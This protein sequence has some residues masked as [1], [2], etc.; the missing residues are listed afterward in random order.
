M[1]MHGTWYKGPQLAHHPHSNPHNSSLGH[2]DY[3]QFRSYP[4][5][6]VTPYHDGHVQGP[7]TPTPC[8]A[9]PTPCNGPLPVPV[10]VPLS[11]PVCQAGGQ[12]SPVIVEGSFAAAAASSTTVGGSSATPLLPSPP[13]KIEQVFGEPSSLGAVVEDYA[14]SLDCP[15]EHTFRKP[16]SNN[17]G[18]SWS[19]SNNNEVVSNNNHHPATPPT[20]PS[21]AT[22]T[23]ATS[24]SAI[25]LNQAQP[26]SQARPNFGSSV[27]SPPTEAD[28]VTAATCKSQES[29]SSN[30]PP[31]PTH[32]PDPSAAQTASSNPTAAAVA[33]AA[34]AAAAAN[35]PIGGVQG[36]NP[37]QGLVHWMSAVMAEHMTG[38]THHDP[39]G[40]VGMH[41][42]WNGNV[43]HAKDI[44]DYNLWPPT[45]RSH[46]HAS[47]HHPMSLKQEYEAKMNDHHHNSLQKG[48]FLDD[49]R[50][51]H[52]AVTGQG[53][54]GL[55]AS[56]G[57]GGGGGGGG[58]VGG[59]SSLGASSHH[60][61]A[62]A[63]HHNQAV[64]A[65]SAALLVVPQ[66]INASK[67]GGPGGVASGAGGHAAG[68]GSGRKYQC[69]M[70][71]QK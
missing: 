26:A 67:M 12:G 17:N 25:N 60:A 56:N 68:G 23:Q 11:V 34:A 66:P 14:L 54:L 59:S 30:P 49:N 61:A 35:M 9:P 38:Q 31:G 24:V 52:H 32:N 69:K 44:S 36:Q 13:I 45:P 7:A 42:M 22:A 19:S 46:Q 63:H 40:A 5:F 71:P 57:I 70:C 33:A 37:T 65:A 27:K 4:S 15:V 28:A 62:A 8:P 58:S 48:H 3:H 6:V 1:I 47:E 10:P 55:G 39:T 2:S 16:H 29:S 51:E 41:Y 21:E 18:Y 53:G 64:A 50:L 43:D 20:P